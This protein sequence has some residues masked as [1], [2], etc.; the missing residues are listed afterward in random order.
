MAAHI[1]PATS[2]EG[3]EGVKQRL[4]RI[5]YLAFKC[6]KVRQTHRS[7]NEV[8]I[9]P[10][11]P[12]LRDTGARIR[13]EITHSGNITGPHTHTEQP[14]LSQP[15]ETFPFPSPNRTD[16]LLLHQYRYTV[17]PR[18]ASRFTLPNRPNL[19]QRCRGTCGFDTSQT[20]P[21]Y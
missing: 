19:T 9:I 8:D 3:F 17:P 7:S 12:C 6:R 10:T 13:I 1:P 20:A 14:C 18:N 16:F 21:H 5:H 4:S 15:P 2:L 11:Q